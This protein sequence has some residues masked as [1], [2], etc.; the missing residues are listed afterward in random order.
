MFCILKIELFSPLDKICLFIALVHIYKSSHVSVSNDNF[1]NDKKRE[2]LELRL[3]R[4]VFFRCKLSVTYS[5]YDFNQN[6]IDLD[7][8]VSM[9][10]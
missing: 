10:V 8:V 9:T 7:S 1:C 5:K 6:V 4:A 3:N 2:E